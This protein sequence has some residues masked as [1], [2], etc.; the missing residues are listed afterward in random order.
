MTMLHTGTSA[1]ALSTPPRWVRVA[2]GA[3]L[4]VAGLIVLGDIAVATFISTLVIGIVAIAG[5]FFEMVH[6][7]WNR[8]WGGFLWQILLG[9]LYLA[10][11]IVLVSQPLAGALVLTYILGMLLLLSGI[12]RVALSLAHWQEVGWIMLVSGIFGILAGL[13]I[14]TGFPMTG[15]WVLGLVLGIDL[16]THGM[17][18][19]T[20]GWLAAPARA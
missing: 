12:I 7:F 2:L 11:G 10:F 6:A 1:H 14:L 4:V 5:G 19:L 17:A 8:G 9:A 18:W 20:S 3:V 16:I 15:L 13:V